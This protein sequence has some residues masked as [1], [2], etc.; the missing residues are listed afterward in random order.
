MLREK[1]WHDNRRAPNRN[2]GALQTGKGPR[3]YVFEIPARQSRFAVMLPVVCMEYRSLGE[4]RERGLGGGRRY[5]LQW[6][7]LV[8]D[9]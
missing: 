5:L 3:G 1:L 2:A 7:S 6:I 4:I 8:A 9:A